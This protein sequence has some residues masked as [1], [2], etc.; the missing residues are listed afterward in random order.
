MGRMNSSLVQSLSVVQRMDNVRIAKC[1]RY[2]R[3]RLR[4]IT[5]VSCSGNGLSFILTM[6]V[7]VDQTRD[8]NAHSAESKWL[9]RSSH[10][11]EHT[12]AKLTPNMTDIVVQNKALSVRAARQK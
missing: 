9:K 1:S 5:V 2:K 7:S 10:T 8:P 6:T 3:I 4:A 12:L 11:V